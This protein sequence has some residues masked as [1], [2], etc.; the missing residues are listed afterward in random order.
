MTIGS[1]IKAAEANAFVHEIIVVSD[2]STD[3]TAEVARSTS[4]TVIELAH[5]AGKGEALS[6]GVHKA[7]GD[8]LVFLDADLT[9]FTPAMLSVLV[10]PVL[11]NQCEMFTLQ[12]E[13]TLQGIPYLMPSLVLGG[14]R[15]LTRRL[16]CSV[17]K[18]ERTGFQVELALNYHA[19]R[20]KRKTG[21]AVMRGLSHIIKEKKH[22]F[23]LGLAERAKMTWE[24][25]QAYIKLYLL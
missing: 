25:I 17:P 20:Q 4:A 13:R 9:G 18:H 12:R 3:D 15:A 11:R 22:G 21:F 1:V 7:R 16:W 19:M 8:V 14:E 10:F 5:N 23:A 24:C 2:G 6:I